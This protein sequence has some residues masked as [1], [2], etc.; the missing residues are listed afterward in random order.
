[1]YF[2]VVRTV[3]SC[4]K[5]R[6][7][8]H[9]FLITSMFSLFFAF[10]NFHTFWSRRDDPNR[11]KRSPFPETHVS[12]LDILSVKRSQFRPKRRS[13]MES[14][15]ELKE[16][17]GSASD[18]TVF[19]IPVRI[20]IIIMILIVINDT[21]PLNRI[22]SCVACFE[23]FASVKASTAPQALNNSDYNSKS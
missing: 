12:N 14:I 10:T 4:V 18:H 13:Q 3:S 19:R 22:I 11:K 20:M 7:K 6:P 21:N 9:A 16:T 2:F 1:M 17:Q 15:Q 8:H 23:I 5:I